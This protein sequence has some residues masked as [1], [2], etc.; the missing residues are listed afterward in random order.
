MRLGRFFQKLYIACLLT[1]A[2]TSN[3][4]ANHLFFPLSVQQQD[5]T[6]SKPA[7][8]LPFPFKDQPAF[9]TPSQDSTKLFLSKPGNIDFEIEYDHETGQYIFYEKIGKLN[10]RLPPST[11]SEDFIKY[12]YDKTIK[13][14]WRQ[15]SKIHDMDRRWSLITQLCSGGEAVSRVFG[16]N[17]VNIQ[18]HGYV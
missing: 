18:P 2:G 6:T 8:T 14:Y 11:S 9:G 4:A 12:Y 3:A 16:G 17:V 5:T 10:Y 13:K 1:I 15:R 7:G